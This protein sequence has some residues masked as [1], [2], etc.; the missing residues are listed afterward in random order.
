[1]KKPAKS[2]MYANAKVASLAPFDA[3]I[4]GDIDASACV[5]SYG[6][7]PEQ[8]KRAFDAACN[9]VGMPGPVYV[10]ASQLSPV[11]AFAALEGLD[12]EAVIVADDVAAAL[13]AQ[14]YR[15]DVMPDA[16]GRLF[17]RP[18]VAFSSFEADLAQERTKQR[19]WALLKTLRRS[20]ERRKHA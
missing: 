1:M 20:S 16:Y 6:M 14:A 11:D 10:D 12:P 19:D 5:V 17:G 2:N 18:Y 9:G 13:L 15:A 3:A 4:D 8:V 7:L